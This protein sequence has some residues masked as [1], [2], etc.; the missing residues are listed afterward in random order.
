VIF[1]EDDI[2]IKRG[3]KLKDIKNCRFSVI[4]SVKHLPF[5]E[6]KEYFN[7][8]VREFLTGKML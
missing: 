3:R 8:L 2:F 6:D 5:L 1:G 4:P 7:M